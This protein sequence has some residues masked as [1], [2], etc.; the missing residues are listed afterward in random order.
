[1]P[2]EG[3][4][5]AL[6]GLDVGGSDVDIQN[7]RSE[8]CSQGPYANVGQGAHLRTSLRLDFDQSLRTNFRARLA[9]IR[10]IACANEKPGARGLASLIKNLAGSANGPGMARGLKTRAAGGS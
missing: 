4:D 3:G 5:H 2:V 8:A 6:Q 7:F 10:L 1:M 9:P